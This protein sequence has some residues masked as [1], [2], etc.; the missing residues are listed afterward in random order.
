MRREK[1]TRRSPKA[2]YEFSSIYSPVFLVATG[3]PIEKTAAVNNAINSEARPP[4]SA[5]KPLCDGSLDEQDGG[6]PPNL[7]R[8]DR[9]PGVLQK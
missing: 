5:R 1:I 6:S 7:Q 2:N 3:H 4:A 9:S 8:S